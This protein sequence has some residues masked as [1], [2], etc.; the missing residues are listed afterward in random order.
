MCVHVH[1]CGGSIC[2]QCLLKVG[3]HP[4]NHEGSCYTG[5]WL[6]IIQDAGR[7]WPQV[8][9]SL[10][11]AKEGR[12]GL[13]ICPAEDFTVLQ[14]CPTAGSTSSGQE[15]KWGTGR[16]A[17]LGPSW[18]EGEWNVGAQV[19]IPTQ[20]SRWLGM[21]LGARW[22]CLSELPRVGEN[23]SCPGSK[24]SAAGVG[25]EVEVEVKVH[26]WLKGTG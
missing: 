4:V 7:R 1:V 11:R 10:L 12:P 6:S 15:R 20:V 17:M 8:S 16:G 24:G 14:Q 2:G 23:N 18:R 5:F 22:L 26:S 25:G 3:Q 9:G 21:P 13:P 19:W